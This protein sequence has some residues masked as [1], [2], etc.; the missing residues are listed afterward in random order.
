[1]GDLRAQTINLQQSEEQE[2]DEHGNVV[3]RCADGSRA[4]NATQIT[5]ARASEARR[6]ELM[7]S[8]TAAFSHKQLRLCLMRTGTKQNSPLGMAQGISMCH[9]VA[10]G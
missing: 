10:R 9:T 4:L 2:L 8:E 6:Q 1:M 5:K 3:K 7:G